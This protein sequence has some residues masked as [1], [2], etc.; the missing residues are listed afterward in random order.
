MGKKS[1]Q[2][3]RRTNQP[4]RL[5]APTSR[6]QASPDGD[7]VANTV[8]LSH[9]DL[10]IG[11]VA[12]ILVLGIYVPTLSPY[13]LLEDDG[14]FIAIGATLGTAHP[15]G[16][17]IFTLLL[18]LFLKLPFATVPLGAHVLSAL[19]GALGS[20]A[21]FYCGRQ[22]GL[23]RVI[24]LLAALLFSVHGLVWSQAVR[25]EVYSF[26]YFLTFAALALSLHIYRSPQHKTTWILG[27][28]VAGLAVANHWPLFVL[29]SPGL[30]LLL[31]RVRPLP[32]KAIA[33]SGGVFLI[34]VCLAYAYLMLR[35][36]A[37]PVVQFSGPILNFTE[38]KAYFLRETF[39]WADDSHSAGWI[40]RLQYFGW[41]SWQTLSSFTALGGVIAIFGTYALF[42]RSRYL[43][44]I[45]LLIWASQ[46]YLL[47]ILLNRDFDPL[48]VG[49]FQV[50][51]LVSYGIQALFIGYG[52][53]AILSWSI[54]FFRNLD[55]K[56]AQT[57]GVYGVGVLMVL[58]LASTNFT[59]VKQAEAGM[60]ENYRRYVE[61]RAELD[62][63]IVLHNTVLAS[64]LIYAEG[65]ESIRPDLDVV[66]QNGLLL[67][68]IG[69]EGPFRQQPGFVDPVRVIQ[70]LIA[71]NT[72]PVLFLGHNSANLLC[73]KCGTIYEGFL[74]KVQPDDP[75]NRAIN[76]TEVDQAYLQTL[77]AAMPTNPWADNERGNQLTHFGRVVG[78][79]I[80]SN[81]ETSIDIEAAFADQRA[82]P[83]VQIGAVR[84]GLQ[85]WD[86]AK[87]DLIL[88][89]L[90]DTEDALGQADLR[91]QDRGQFYTMRGAFSLFI[92]DKIA[93]R[94]YLEQSIAVWDDPNNVA[95][96]LLKS[97]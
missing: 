48:G 93:A 86:P 7:T 11:A 8:P 23:G 97:L 65:T 26:N 20:F 82:A 88:T 43:A 90:N 28:L 70:R 21:L 76:W 15:P 49:I 66:N 79:A 72:R 50:Y 6:A 22:I 92:N 53:Q 18:W 38:L 58:W 69:I 61:D 54:P 35:S 37:E 81:M 19:L 42:K 83:W 32:I 44:L 25:A 3:Q 39:A 9:L 46:S 47:L 57:A 5:A 91:T 60:A 62:S 59:V 55:T 85:N 56:R 95:H 24:A 40:D 36:Q 41:F 51:S 96:E 80:L 30:L 31:A 74:V 1:N 4:Q 52:L 68:K 78:R 75:L 67:G 16:Y 2:Q 14:L 63:L 45:L 12:A 13:V 71:A 33:L 89:W 17:P 64:S 27:G 10:G 94:K 29:S 34:T 73:P 84:E 87:S 77:L